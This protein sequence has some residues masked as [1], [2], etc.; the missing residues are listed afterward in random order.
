MAVNCCVFPSAIDGLA[1][2]TAIETNIGGPTVRVVEPLIDHAWLQLARRKD[3]EAAQGFLDCLALARQVGDQFNVG[4]ALAGLSTQAGLQGR[5]EEALGWR[6][7][8]DYAAGADFRVVQLTPPG[9]ACSVTFGT[10]V[11]SA[12]RGPQGRQRNPI[13]AVA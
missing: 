13:P 10:A 8:A 5:W 6:E 4:E 7:D 1:G 3:D 11:T 2:V 12:G 9:S